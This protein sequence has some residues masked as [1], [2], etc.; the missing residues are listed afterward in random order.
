MLTRNRV[1]HT[2]DT[3]LHE[4][5][6]AFN[7]VDVDIPAHVDTFSVLDTVVRVFPCRVVEGI[8]GRQFIGVD[9]RSWQHTFD[10]VRQQGRPLTLRTGA[11]HTRPLRCTMPNTG[12]LCDE[13]IVGRPGGVPRR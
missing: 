11:A 13:S 9:E 10:E 1:I 6:E 5:P 4:R 8:V 3:A 2:I 7:R 12:V